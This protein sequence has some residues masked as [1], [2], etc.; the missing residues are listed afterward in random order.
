MLPIII[1]GSGLA[2]YMLARE[3]RKL[4][5]ST[6][7]QIITQDDGMY[8][9]KPQLSSAFTHHKTAAALGTTSAAKMEEQLTAKIFTHT[10]VLKIEP[11]KHL[12]YTEKAVLPYSALVLAQGAEVIPAPLKGNAL[13]KVISINNLEDYAQFRDLVAHKKRIAILGAG[14][15]GCEFTNDLLNGGFAIDVIALAATPLDVL[16]PP[17]LGQTLQHALATKGVRWHLNRSIQSVEQHNNE[18]SLLLS[19]GSRITTD[20]VLSAIGLRPVL[21]L[22]TTAGIATS[23]GIV[24]DKYLRTSSADIY[25]LGD[26]AEVCG[27]V[28]FYVAP[29][30]VSARALAQNLAGNPTAV[31]YSPMPVILKTPACPI[32]VNPPP[33]GIMGQWHITG[34]DPD[35]KALFYDQ[36]NQLQGFALTGKAVIEKLSLVKELPLLF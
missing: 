5:Q 24:V 15:V 4:N 23:R 21:Q 31:S 14:L 18:L 28:L 29:L 26:C 33:R 2:G 11:E 7:L 19:D 3:F 30:I 12:V 9:S 10:S 17:A 25:A 8:Y 1:I 6:P 22:A 16:L 32:V 27:H 13:D 35:K 34:E 36:A 20:I